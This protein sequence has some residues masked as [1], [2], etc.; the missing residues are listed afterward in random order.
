MAQTLKPTRKLVAV[1]DSPTPIVRGD[2]EAH[3]RVPSDPLDTRSITLIVENM[4][5]GGCMRKVETAAMAVPGTLAARANLSTRG[6]VSA[7]KN[8]HFSSRHPDEGRDPGHLSAV[9]WPK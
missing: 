3:P 7:W 5:C 6:S 9:V 1:N 4:H 8:E 2:A